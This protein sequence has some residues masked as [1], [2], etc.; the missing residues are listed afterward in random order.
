MRKF[1]IAGNWKM[2]KTVPEAKDFILKL[3]HEMPLNPKC[4]VLVIPPFTAVYPVA[5]LAINSDIKVGAQNLFWEK[6][7]AFT[8]E[9]SGDMVAAAGAEFVVVGHSERR[10]YFNE[11]DETV[12]KR[13]KAALAAYLT[14]I[15]CVGELLAERNANQAKTV[16]EKQIREAYAGLLAE[17]AAKTVIAYE[18]VWAI[19]TG[20]V[21]TPDQAQEM[22]AFIRGLIVDLY[23][24][25][26]ADKMIIQYGGSLNPANAQQLLSLPDIDGGL[27]GGASLKVAD[28]VQI[29][30]IADGIVK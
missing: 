26:V 9:I 4:T 5:D 22:H 13:V 18:P 3:I 23:G 15:I 27:I 25:E 14:P 28:F 29:I 11:T 24:Q 19:G 8:A 2:N 30:K 20:V 21:A 7:G 17:D 16:V 6:S 1:L 10:Q 12:N